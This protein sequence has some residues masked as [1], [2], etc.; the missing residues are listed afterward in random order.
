MVV[1]FKEKGH[2]KFLLSRRSYGSRR[3]KTVNSARLFVRRRKSSSARHEIPRFLV[4]Q[5]MRH[6]NL[7]LTSFLEQKNQANFNTS[8][9]SNFN[10]SQKFTRLPC[11]KSL[12]LLTALIR[13]IGR[14][15]ADRDRQT[16]TLTETYL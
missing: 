5:K 13:A 10:S 8:T 15:T 7:L 3:Q 11:L 14:F 4:N 2:R 1:H 16:D 9:K 6:G 12:S